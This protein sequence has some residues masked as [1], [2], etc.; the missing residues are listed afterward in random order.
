VGQRGAVQNVYSGN[1]AYGRRGAFYNQNT[2]VAGAGGKVTWGNSA[3]GNQGTA[4]RAA[5][6]N[7]NTGNVTHIAA[8][9][10]ESGGFIAANGQVIVGKD[11]NYYRPNGQGGWDQITRPGSGAGT[12]ERRNMSGQSSG[13][14]VPASNLQEQQ[15]HSLNN[16]YRARQQS[17]QRQ[18]SFQNHRP[19]FRGGGGLRR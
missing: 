3:T 9:K 10:G 15:I 2:G 14:R 12:L 7:P 1:Y 16:E 13:N 6:Y 18:Q 19:V 4:G 5:I 17:A 11:G 8:G